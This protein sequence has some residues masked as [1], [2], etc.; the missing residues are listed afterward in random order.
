MRAAGQRD[1]RRRVVPGLDMKLEYKTVWISDTHLG[2][3]GARVTAHITLPGR[4]LVFMPTSNHNGVS[5]R[6]EGEQ[7]QQAA[8]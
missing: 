5:R 4:Y 2:S 8:Q 6:I 1:P 3:K 7:E